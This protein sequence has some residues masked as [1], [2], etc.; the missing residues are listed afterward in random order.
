V[1]RHHVEVLERL[2]VVD[3]SCANVFDELTPVSDEAGVV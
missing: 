1:A 3:A 2:E